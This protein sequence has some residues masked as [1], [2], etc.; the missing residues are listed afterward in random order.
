VDV[1]GFEAFLEAIPFVGAPVSLIII[2][3]IGKME[4]FSELFRHLVSQVLD[5]DQVVLATIA[6]KGC[7]F[8]ERTKKR[9]DVQL[10]E[11]VEGRRET[12]VEEVVGKIKGLYAL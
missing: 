12:M 8:I 6:L 3:E 4:C 9:G 7:G 10:I 11:L 2:D 5:S 1:K